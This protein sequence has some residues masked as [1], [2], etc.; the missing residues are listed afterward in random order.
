MKKTLL[1]AAAL[2]LSV[3]T[4]AQDAPKAQNEQKGFIFTTVKENPVTS[5]KNQASSGTCWCFSALGFIESEIIRTNP[6]AAEG[7]DL[8]EMFIVSKAYTEK[9]EKYIRTDGHINYAQGSS[10]GDVLDVL[11]KHGVCP[12]SEMPG[13]NYGTKKHSHG[14]L[15]AGL[16]GYLD[17]ILGNLSRRGTT[18]S[19]AW[20]NGLKG[21]LAAYLGPEPEKFTVNGKEYTPKSWFD[22]FGLNLDDYIDITSW[23]HLSY[24]EM[25]PVEVADNWRWER[26]YNIHLDEMM[27]VI[28]NAIMNGYTV[29][30][31]SDVSEP[32]FTR[33]GACV[34]VIPTPEAIKQA[35]EPGSDAAKWLG[36]TPGATKYDIKGPVDE[37][38]VT[39]ESRQKGY[40]E[41][42]TTDDHGM[43]IYGIA[44][45]QNGKKYY[46]VKNSWGT[47]HDYKG[48]WYVSEAYVKAKTMDIVVNKNC[49][50]KDLAK[51]LGLK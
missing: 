23:T 3:A 18:L 34:G 24:Y 6:K 38:E 37:I 19:T 4:F 45:D 28:D 27:A 22:S 36:I 35:K 50:T 30:W 17:G 9:A 7:L 25:H 21:I 10:F 41:K 14:E 47:D 48:I 31:A 40:D 5:V 1:F 2:T 42:S 16:K 46:I 33:K 51:K 49:L 20:L 32:G 26:A 44:K 11:K 39:P 29:A 8:S 13:L 43:L 15:Q 12:N